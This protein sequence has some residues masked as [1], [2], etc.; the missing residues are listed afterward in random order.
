MLFR[1]YRMRVHG[2]LAPSLT[3]DSGLDLLSRVTR[4]QA[5]L[6]VDDQLIN[7]RGVDIPPT[8]LALNPGLA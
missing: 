3:I 1:S 4:Y 8:V 2:K 5:L 7:S 6:P